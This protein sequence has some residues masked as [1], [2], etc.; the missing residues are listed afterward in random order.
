MRFCRWQHKFT[1]SKLHSSTASCCFLN[2]PEPLQGASTKIISNTFSISEYELGS[3]LVTTTL[4]VPH[5]LMFCANTSALCLTT[6]LAINALSLF[7]SEFSK[8][9]FPPGDAHTSNANKV[10]SKSIH[11]FKACSINIDPASCT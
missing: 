11:D 6:S 7:N 3:L 5:L 1:L 9:L 10:A 2:K 4:L 8:V